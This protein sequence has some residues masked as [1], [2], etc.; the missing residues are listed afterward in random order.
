[1]LIVKIVLTVMQADVGSP[2]SKSFFSA[3]PTKGV[4]PV[5]EVYVDDRF[6]ELDRTLDQSTAVVSRAVTD[7]ERSSVEPLQIASERI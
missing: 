1:M 3:K 6:A 2:P 7:A 4:Q 5:V